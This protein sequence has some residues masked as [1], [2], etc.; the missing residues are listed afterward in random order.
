MIKHKV[1]IV[2][3][4][5]LILAALGGCASNSTVSVSEEN[6]ELYAAELAMRPAT[7]TEVDDLDGTNTRVIIRAR[8]PIN[9]NRPGKEQLLGRL[10]EA[11]DKEL[12][13]LSLS[14]VDRQLNKML[15]GEVTLSSIY[16]AEAGRDNADALILVVIDEY[17]TVTE[18][19]TKAKLLKKMIGKDETYGECSYETQFSG[20]FR[21]QSIPEL[22]QLAQF[23]FHDSDSDSFDVPNERACNKK[24]S[25]HIRKLNKQLIDDVVCKNKAEIANVLAPTGHVTGQEV[26]EDT[27]SLEVSLGSD[28]GVSKGDVLRLYHELSGEYY[29]EVRVTRVY[30]KRAQAVLSTLQKDATIYEGDFVRPYERGLL[31][32]FRV[33]CLL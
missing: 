10:H 7:L 23:D 14:V 16:G 17:E 29:G 19:S 1:I 31:D 12:G 8:Q 21:I 9:P 2:L 24:F 18:T 20:Y 6:R 5:G 30:A 4:A 32:I 33:N 11:L 22:T 28:M 13:K 15:K 3:F 25:A 26:L 27:V